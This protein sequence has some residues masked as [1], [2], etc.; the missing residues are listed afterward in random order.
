MNKKL[1][2]AMWS[3][4]RNISTTLMRSFGNR[5]D[6]F[7][8]DEP[9]YGYFLN[10]TK[11]DHPMRDLIIKN[12][13]T[14]WDIIKNNLI[15]K[16]PLN[17]NIWYQKQMTQHLLP[18]DDIS[19]L[20]NVTNCFLIRN[21]KD[22][23]ISYSKIYKH[24]SIGLLGFPQLSKIFNYSLKEQNKPIVIN[25]RDILESPE[26]SLRKLCKLL[27]INFSEKM[28]S[29]KIGAKE[30]DGEWGKHWYKQLYKTT[31]FLDYHPNNDTLP[32]KYYPLYKECNH[33][34]KTIKKH[35]IDN[36]N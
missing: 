3:G 10:E 28:L 33:Y 12:N 13:E 26:K 23:I 30:Y 6:T 31:G 2:V 7:V 8:S 16:I 24:L 15:G 9:F 21:P 18:Q 1:K 32:N 27:S 22:V 4:P 36:F 11:I 20:S 5:P 19:W 29:W 17:K 35:Q 34:Y 14:N 25:S